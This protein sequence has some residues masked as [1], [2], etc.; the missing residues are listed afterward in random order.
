MSSIEI[1]PA[2][3]EAKARMRDT[4]YLTC[5]E[6]AVRSGKTTESLVAWLY[7]VLQ[8]PDRAF[9]MSGNT[10]GSLTKNCIDNDFGLIA[11]TA[12]AATKEVDRDGNRFISFAG[13]KIYYVG[14]D[15]KRSYKKI[16]GMTVGGWYAD[17]INLH[18][19]GFVEEA[20]RRTFA[21]RDR[22]HFWT[23]NP[24]VPTHWIYTDFIDAYG[25]D[26]LP[27]FRLHHLTLDDNPAITDVR[28]TEIARQYSGVFYQRYVLGMR[29]RAEGSCYPSFHD[30]LVLDE[31][32]DNILFVQIGV[33]I[34]GT[35]SATA[36]E[37]VGFFKPKDKPVCVAVLDEHYDRENH[38]TE[39]VL[40][41]FAAF[42]HRCR[43]RGWKVS[44]GYVDSAEQLIL[45]SMRN[46]G[47]VNIHNSR[48]HPVND[49]IRFADVMMARER[50]YI[51]RDC[52]ATYDAIHGAVWDDKKNGEERLDDGTSNIDSLDAME[53]A[54]ERRMGELL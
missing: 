48:K 14:A 23:L 24:D 38:S 22:R 49:R 16:R 53:Y 26:S 39:K 44:D 20:F 50:F 12:G 10:Q 51:M 6:G 19:R 36:F 31:Y 45:K 34:G 28:K 5:W 41:D 4:G 13:N 54:Y 52:R 33:D 1:Y 11:L 18:D 47:V 7:Y 30:G 21:S 15:N 17:E 32:P 43:D 29:V 2:S 35:G 9:I 27:G 42:V 25:K 37:A 3:A 46:L 40:R 8:S